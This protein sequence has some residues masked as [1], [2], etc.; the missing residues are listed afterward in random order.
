MPPAAAAAARWQAGTVCSVSDSLPGPDGARVDGLTLA[1]PTQQ[2]TALAAACAHL[3]RSL[4]QGFRLHLA[5]PQLHALRQLLP[6]VVGSSLKGPLDPAAAADCC[7]CGVLLARHNLLDP[8]DGCCCC[9]Q[10]LLLRQVGGPERVLQQR[11]HII[12]QG[13]QARGAALVQAGHH[14]LQH[15]CAQ[16]RARRSERKQLLVQHSW[17]VAESWSTNERFSQGCPCRCV[18]PPS[19]AISLTQQ[20]LEEAL[21][22]LGRVQHCRDLLGRGDPA[23]Q[24]QGQHLVVRLCARQA[25]RQAGSMREG[26]S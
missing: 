26:R 10:H 6:G 5:P 9:R 3:G 20:P 21:V 24:E 18:P 11:P 7:C 4:A 23:G 15:A 13:G 2:A 22:A 25:G 1:T 12:N 8:A 19:S 16:S 17:R 14:R